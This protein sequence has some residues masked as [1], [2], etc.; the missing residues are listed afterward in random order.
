MGNLPSLKAI[1]AFEATARHL[2]FSLAANELHVT[3][4]AVSHQIKSLESHL[5]KQL[6]TRASNKVLLTQYG[7]IYFSVVTDSFSRIKSITDHLM[8]LKN[9][10]LKVIAQ[11]SF[12]VDWL[13]PRLYLFNQQNPDI[14]ILL[15]MATNAEHYSS[16]DYD[17]S[18]GTWPAPAN[19]KTQKIRSENWYPVM[20]EKLSNQLN[21]DDVRSILAQPLISS[22]NG[23]DWTLWMQKYNIDPSINLNI[24]HVSHTLLAGKTALSGQG[25]ALACDFLVSDE[26]KRGHLIALKQFSY[27][28]SWG[29]YYIHYHGG[30]Y[31]INNI[32]LFINWLM[33][34]CN[35]SQG[36]G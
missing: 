11:S 2:N 20:T 4:S 27:T 24:Q 18:I 21:V 23:Q 36:E 26:V 19:F 28:P 32:T 30:S 9:V 5:G 14:E 35:D 12:A 17:I 16:S 22:E 10:K 1:Q 7:D 8:G 25:I 34:V 29:S 3:Q 6:F 15:S 31:Y 33:Q 13:A